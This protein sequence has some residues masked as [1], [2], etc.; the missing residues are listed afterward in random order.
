MNNLVRLATSEANLTKGWL[1]TRYIPMPEIEYQDHSVR[2]TRGPGGQAKHGYANVT[3]TWENLHSAGAA[4]IRDTVEAV[5]FPSEFYATIPLN[6]ASTPG[7]NWADI[8]GRA[9]PPI[10]TYVGRPDGLGDEAYIVELVINNV[11][12]VNSPSNV[13]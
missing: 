7:K 6:D 2:H 11:R 12:V 1:F 3:L 9:H 5:T 8:A 13:I 10:I 4:W